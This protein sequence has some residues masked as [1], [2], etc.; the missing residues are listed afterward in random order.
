MFAAEVISYEFFGLHFMHCGAAVAYGANFV[1]VHFSPPIAR[2]GNIEL[3]CDVAQKFCMAWTGSAQSVHKF[4]IGL[5]NFVFSCLWIVAAVAFVPA[6]KRISHSTDCGFPAKEFGF[7]NQNH[8]F[9]SPGKFYSSLFLNSPEI[10]SCTSTTWPFSLFFELAKIPA[11][12]VVA[13]AVAIMM[14]AMFRN[15]FTSL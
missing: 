15:D 5:A 9:F 2:C 13:P 6:V 10:S 14:P 8:F 11:T 12:I 4:K 7:F 3:N 1:C